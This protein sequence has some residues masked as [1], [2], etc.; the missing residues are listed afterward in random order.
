MQGINESDKVRSCPRGSV[1]R[2]VFVVSLLNNINHK[3]AEQVCASPSQEY[4]P[5]IVIPL[6]EPE[7]TTAPTVAWKRVVFAVP[8]SR[9]YN[10]TA[11]AMP[12]YEPECTTAPTVAWKRVMFTV[13]VVVHSP[14][15]DDNGISVTVDHFNVD[16]GWVSAK[17]ISHS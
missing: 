3:A 8:P 7:C 1:D 5:A 14:P 13:P 11:I 10:P 6:Y 4:K 17:I 2:Y 16:H 12:M 9:E 15:N